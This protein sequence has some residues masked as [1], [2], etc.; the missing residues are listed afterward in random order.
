M[1]ENDLDDEVCLGHKLDIM[2]QLGSEDWEDVGVLDT[3]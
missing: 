3:N 2:R 1:G